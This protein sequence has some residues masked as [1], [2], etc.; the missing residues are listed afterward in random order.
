M[1]GFGAPMVFAMTCPVTFLE[2]W[3]RKTSS[4]AVVEKY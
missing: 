2:L 4:V 1:L 3:S